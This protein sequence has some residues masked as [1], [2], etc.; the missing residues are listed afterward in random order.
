LPYQIHQTGFRKASG[1]FEYNGEYFNLIEQKIE[2]DTLYAV[3]I[4][5]AY[6]TALSEKMSNFEKAVHNWPNISDKAH[7]LISTFIKDYLPNQSIQTRRSLGWV[8]S[9]DYQTILTNLYGRAR[10][11]ESPPP[12]FS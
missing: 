10:A 9:F 4:K 8:L 3:C 12:E 5:D 7:S 2:G 11:L 6:K 1:K